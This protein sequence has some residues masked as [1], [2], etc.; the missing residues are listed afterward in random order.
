MSAVDLQ[1]YFVIP[2]SVQQEGDLYLVGSADM[3]DFYQFP[4][5]GVKIL[6]MLRS[7]DTVTAI[8]S[9]LADSDEMVDVEDFVAQLADIGFVYPEEQQQLFAE[10]IEAAAKDLR[11]VFSV[12]VRVARALFSPPFV[13]GYLS[14]VLYALASAVEDPAI[15]VNWLAFYTDRNRT[16]LLLC[17]LALSL[18][19]VALHELGHMLAAAR[20]GIK[21]RYGLSNRLWNIVAESD[22]TGI[23]SLPK[24]QRYL[25]MLAGMLV[26]VLCLSLLT[27]ATKTLLQLGAAHFA[28]QAIQALILEIVIGM[29][30]Q[31]NIF[32]R[33]DIHYVLCNY[34]NQPNLDGDARIYLRDVLHRLSFGRFGGRAK[35][36]E[37]HNLNVLRCFSLIWLFG[38]ILSLTT[39][40]GIFLPTMAKYAISAF[41]LLSG[42]PDSVWLAID[43]LA[44]VLITLT[45]LSIGM[46]MWIKER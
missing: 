11:R 18:V 5:Q 4:D 6:D 32:V 26:D 9:R 23:L 43:T 24:S 27:I 3:G 28:I 36:I 8:R 38:R 10:N 15:R 14:I 42:P 2:L 17:V 19:H 39:L 13:A 37:S 30:W 35:H 7:G 46:Y 33:T 25:P 45:M 41:S 22:I 12:D 31:F 21:S 20:Y 16:A 40:F 29:T 1:R 44:Y 34:L